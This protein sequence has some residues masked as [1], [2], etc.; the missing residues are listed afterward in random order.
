MD[1]DIVQPPMDHGPMDVAEEP[2]APPPEPEAESEKAGDGVDFK[3]PFPVATIL[4]LEQRAYI[5]DAQGDSPEWLFP[6]VHHYCKISK[7]P[8][9]LLRDNKASLKK[10]FESVH[11]PQEEI[12]YRG[13]E[14]HANE[15][16]TQ[17]KDHT[18]GSCG[19]LAFL[20]WVLKNR[21]L[22]GECKARALSLCLLMA[23]QAME[24]ALMTANAEVAVMAMMLDGRGSMSCEELHFTP[25]GLCHDSWRRI[26]ARNVGALALW[27]RLSTRCW[28]NRCISSNSQHASF[29]DILFFFAYIWCHQN[30]SMARVNL[31]K[32]AG[33]PS[34]PLFSNKTA[35]MITAFAQHLG[36][37]SLQ[38]LPELKSKTGK[39]RRHCDPVNKMLLLFR[40]RKEKQHRLRIARTHDL[41]QASQRMVKFENYLDSLLYLQLLE[42]TFQ[43][44]VPQVS[45]SWDPS[46]YGGKDTLIGIVYHPEQ[47][48]AAY[49]PS[50]QLSQVLLNDFDTSLLPMAKSKKLT[51]VDGYKD[52]KGFSSSL[53]GIGLSLANFR[54]PDGIL[55]MPLTA[56]QCRVVGPDG[57]VDVLT[58]GTV[59]AQPVV[60][61]NLDL[62]KIPCL[63]SISDQGP[64]N[65]AAL[66]YCMFSKQAFLFW[67]VWDPFHR[68]WNDIKNALKKAKCSAWRVV[69]ELTLVANLNY[70]PF[71]SS[72]WFYKKRS[73]LEQFLLTCN[74]HSGVWLQFQHLICIERRQREPAS[75][76][77]AQRLLDSMG[78]MESFLAKGPLVKLMRWFSWFESM[79]H[80]QGDLFATKM[81]LL[82][83]IE[84]E[85]PAHEVEVKPEQD[86]QKELQELK[87]RKGSWKLAPTLTGTSPS[88]I[89]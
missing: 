47:N 77:D 21:T 15:G 42:K 46:T 52:L 76:E 53:G 5:N 69:L 20:F 58:E 13:K 61:P 73:R 65:V 44:F 36:K 45:V 67:S 28:L 55:W 10:V 72:T 51:R 11:V 30:M 22:R 34:L 8:T 63:V 48:L 24:F 41:G 81:V 74:I 43:D 80:L 31:W 14:E 75:P 89:V 64:N 16:D 82:E 66:N 29:T 79:L 26:I 6:R 7:D 35:Q 68:A 85:G 56:G 37:Q 17:W 57:T 25:P 40:L 83:N 32:A 3:L 62:G 1:F 23:Q 2:G 19:F 33:G 70:G 78:H 60:P 87:K 38:Q 59:Q 18:L 71:G 49:L 86:H 84:E 39:A 9:R 27:E 88:R 12:H 50:Q 54:V 4:E